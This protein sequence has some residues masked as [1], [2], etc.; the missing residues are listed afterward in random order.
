M[1][2]VEPSTNLAR[3]QHV[4]EGRR[5]EAASGQRYDSVD[6]YLG[7]PW[8]SA[9]DGGAA[10]VDLAVAAARRALGGPWGQLTG[11]GRAALM[12]RLGDLIMRD[13]DRLAEIE[14]RDTGKLLR[15]MRGQLGTIPQWFS[16]FSGLADKLEG[17]T[18]PGDKPNFLV[19]TRREP[20]GVVAAIVP[21]NS[22][23][24]LLCWKLAPA[25]AAGCTMVA[26]PSDYSPASAVE[27]AALMDE[28]GFPPGVF[29]VV[30]GFGP[31]VGKA[32]AGH[33]G[34]DK[35]AFT[36]S[37]AVGAQVAAAA[38]A[39]ITGVLLELGGKSAHLVFDDAD[40]DAACNGVL[41][42]VFAATGQTC[43]AGSRLLVCRTVHDQLVQKITERA[44]SIRLGD[45]KAPD[46]E[47]GPVATEP[48][49]RKVLSFL[50]G[51]ATEGATVAA[52]GRPD[53]GLGGFFVQ[54]TVLTGVKPT[55]TVACEEVFGPVLSVIP[56]DTED[57]AIAVAN[58]SRYGLAGAVWT[59]D[60][61]RGH[62]VAH[63][64]R[65]G[66]VWINAY[67]VVGPDVPFGGYGLSG[68]GRENGIEAVHE[69]TQT[70]AIW[71]ELSGGTRDPF[72]LG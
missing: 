52:G 63:A 54:P 7:A 65:T 5:V 28:A 68:L 47:M 40:L 22:P 30:T 34:I 38:A 36:G 25:L 17:T 56:F 15:E 64:M 8:A 51:A 1:T 26:K 13:A 42:G 39:N 16:Y 50:E 23:L 10:D 35:I 27:L 59:K 14:T 69:Y 21:W 20:A 18:I 9:A 49:Y 58:D 24:L 70:K 6:P 4:I 29:N 41:A 53:D 57:E 43:M 66:T 33:P 3:Y 62:R 32:L 37:T 48:Q 61:H 44:R 19:Y 60:I 45:P 71:V 31:A 12:R 11:F 46:T 67:R 2:T 55:M 72:T